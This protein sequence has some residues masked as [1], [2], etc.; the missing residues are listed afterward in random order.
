MWFFSVKNL[1]SNLSI[2]HTF[3]FNKSTEKKRVDTSG[4]VVNS[5][6]LRL[7]KLS[8]TGVAGEAGR[9]HPTGQ[10]IER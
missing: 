10:A 8:L 1:S 3:H 5:G 2:S 7:S 4:I 9:V 6:D